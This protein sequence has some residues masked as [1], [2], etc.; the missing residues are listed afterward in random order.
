MYG[1]LQRLSPHWKERLDEKRAIHNLDFSRT[2]RH[3]EEPMTEAQKRDTPPA[4]H[5]IVR[6]HPE[7]GQQCLFLGDH[8]EHILGMPYD[9]GRAWIEELNTLAVHPD[10]TYKHRWQPNE[11]LVWDNRCVMHR[12][13]PYDPATQGR[14]IRRCTVLGT[15]PPI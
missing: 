1:A 6:T 8:A 12:V 7:T 9:E 15:T 2:R 11:L 13:T 4:D 14:T 5:P 3:G 10:L